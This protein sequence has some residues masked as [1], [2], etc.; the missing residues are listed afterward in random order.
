MTSI[1]PDTIL[2]TP[3]P[4]TTTAQ[5]K[6]AQLR[7]YGSRDHA[8]IDLTAR[9]AGRLNDIVRGGDE[10]VC[11]PMQGSGTFC[12]EAALGTLMPK[13]A[14]ALVCING[15]YGRR[16][17]TIC[18]IIGRRRTILQ[19]D[20]DQPITAA[21]VDAALAADLSL[22]HVVVVHCETS[23][24]ILNPLAEISAVVARHRRG[25][26]VDAMSSFGALDIDARNIRFDGLVAASGKCL[27]GVPGVGFAIL[28]KAA[29]EICRSNCHSL[30]LDLYDQWRAFERSGQ[31]RFTPPTTV[32][33]ALSE[34]LD[35]FD[36]QGG[37]AGRSARYRANCATLIDGMEELGFVSFLP[38]RLQAPI[39]TTW[40][41]PADPQYDFKAF[42][43]KVHARGFALYPGKL[44]RGDT[45]RIGCIGAIEK[46]DILAAVHA[47]SAVVQEM[48]VTRLKP[49]PA[50]SHRSDSGLTVSD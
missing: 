27:E 11:V 24:G 36:V 46:R 39:I 10:H 2:L 6:A 3:G 15:E 25:L 22:S 43:A 14:H 1:T 42:Y 50:E 13:S 21:P 38:R 30:A 47:I 7:D 44:T 49:A 18:D 26:I 45:F 35:Q 41:A 37:I 34:A 48:G 20:E 29:L 4:L 28:R 40:H 12:V 19:T 33:A 23:T 16:I 17:A 31:W 5:T 32:V 9:L 8:F